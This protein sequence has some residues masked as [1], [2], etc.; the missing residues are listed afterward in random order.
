M[1]HIIKQARTVAILGSVALAMASCGDF[2]DITPRNMVTEDNFWNEKADIDQYMAGCYTAMQSEA[3]ITRCIVWGEVRSDNLYPGSTLQNAH[4]DLYQVMRENLLSTNGFT[5][6]VD[7]YYVINKCNNI[8]Q[9][10]P[11]VSEKDP[12]YRESEVKATIAEATALRSLC[13]FYLI[14]AFENVPFYRQ[15]VQQEDE[16]VVLPASNF[17]FVLEQ[18]VSDLEA[19][20]GDALDHYPTTANDGVGQTYN[21]NCNRITRSA[22]NAMLC[23]MYLWQGQWQ[24]AINV[25]DEIIALKRSDYKELYGN[26]TSMTATGPQIGDAAPYG[27]TMPLYANTSGNPGQA[28]DAI[29]GDGNS[30]ESIFELSFNYRGSS[31]N[32]VMSTALG[33]LYGAGITK[34]TDGLDPNDGAGLLAVN[35]SIVSDVTGSAFAYFRH[36]NDARFYTNFQ[37]TDKTYGEAYIRKG[38]ASAT[39]LMQSTDVNEV[40]YA[41]YQSS[42]FTIPGDMNRNW[43]FYR[44]TDVMLMKAEALT[45]LVS[46]S[47]TSEQDIAHLQ[48]AFDLAWLVQHRSIATQSPDANNDLRYQG[49]G[50]RANMLTLIREERNRELMFEGKRWFDLVRQ[51]RLEGSPNFVRS[52]VTAK[53]SGSGGGNLFANMESL[54]WPY[55]K[56]ELKV[57][58]LL[59]QKA[60]YA[61]E[62][63]NELEMN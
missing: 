45:R 26:R 63:D 32:Y 40:N 60:T 15:A 55:N 21:S 47:A 30:F 49:N 48:E 4:Y 44:L 61:K 59:H 12:S 25:A 54:F 22:I 51:A 5:R 42:A 14:R 35:P 10:A 62:A 36:K 7:F 57:D 50:N 38:V 6:W 16:V 37:A 9:R 46:D 41:S 13:Y 58:T 8:I 3:F 34:K 29:F 24:K 31:P 23:D 56:D 17:D 11:E 27:T 2:L 19:V 33:R 20:K 28:F 52:N 39:T 53:V 43:I 1:K 18:I